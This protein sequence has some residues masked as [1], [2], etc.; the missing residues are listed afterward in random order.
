MR[1]AA[2][3]AVA[4]LAHVAGVVSFSLA[5]LA[6]AAH[7]RHNHMPLSTKWSAEDDCNNLASDPLRC[8]EKPE[9]EPSVRDLM[10]LLERA[11]PAEGKERWA[12]TRRYLYQHR[13]R[14]GASR[15]ETTAEGG[16][17]K[18][19]RRSND[20]PLTAESVRRI[21]S[22][23]RA[24]FPDDLELQAKILQRS[25]RIL[26]QHRSIESRLVPTVEFLR[27]LYGGL[28][29]GDGKEGGMLHEAMKRNT[30][31]LLVR[32]VGYTAGGGNASVLRSDG[33]GSSNGHSEVEEYLLND[34]GL[35]QSGIAKLKRNHP[36]IFQLSLEDTV[37][38]AG[39]YLQ[40]LLGPR[41]RK[42]VAK[43]AIRH[44]VLLQLDVAANLAP[45][46]DF[47]RASCDLSSAELADVV[48]ATP[49]VLGL[50]V[51]G[52]LA[53]TIQYL[54]EILQSGG[55]P[56]E[57]ASRKLLRKCVRKHPQ[58]LA[59]SL[60]NLSAK[61]DYFDG[62]DEKRDWQMGEC[63]EG[64]AKPKRS[65]AASILAGAP[66]AYSL[67]LAANIAP[68]VHF[69]SGLWEGGGS[70]LADGLRECPQ[71]LT[72]SYEGNIL[73]TLSF[74]NMTGYIDLDADGRPRTQQQ[75]PT[76][77]R[78]S[79][80]AIRSR[81]IATSLYNR[82]LPRW[83]YVLEEREKQQLLAQELGA[84]SEGSP[85]KAPSEAIRPPLHLLAGASDEVFCRQMRLSLDEYL[86]YK[87]EAIPRLKFSSQFAIWL[88]TG[89]PIEMAAAPTEQSPD[90]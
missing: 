22:F 50:S 47:L 7:Q 60:G 27:G 16:V 63:G 59:L 9:E 29:G 88:K 40:S 41:H 81:Y 89:R 31:L 69:F 1:R 5:F 64:N 65:L 33:D 55:E 20:G 76:A 49:G 14:T 57:E 53:P 28:A 11:Y 86:S 51:E 39:E 74:F 18:R 61:R 36:A 3:A 75:P 19:R 37:K 56:D 79:N 46:A 17:T 70:S 25:P 6:P 32:G 67:S 8:A 78:P 83:H 80:V 15:K 42:K 90:T 30:D 48:A 12:K 72:L 21:L 82:L 77:K 26:G 4:V 54:L 35:S 52:N 84:L 71:I 66:S 62:I 2:A 23:L 38:P 73:P 45:T 13:A 44:P 43:I 85:K 58:I 87:E 34:L 10:A 24:A 68:K